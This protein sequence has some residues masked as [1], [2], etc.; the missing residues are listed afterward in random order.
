MSLF[1]LFNSPEIYVAK[2]FAISSLLFTPRS[3]FFPFSYKH[4]T[5]KLK[6]E[7]YSYDMTDYYIP[8]LAGW[9]FVVPIGL[10]ALMLLMDILNSRR[11]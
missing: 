1:K 11:I 2:L 7:F 9:L 4:I 5:V 6:Y 3:V 10:I 8:L